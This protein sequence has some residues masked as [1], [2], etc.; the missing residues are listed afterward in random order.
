MIGPANL[1]D[2]L[3]HCCFLRAPTSK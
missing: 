1:M 2:D 3:L